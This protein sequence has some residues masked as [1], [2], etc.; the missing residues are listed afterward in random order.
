M[1]LRGGVRL[2]VVGLTLGVALVGH[3]V[4]EECVGRMG[5]SRGSSRG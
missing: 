1:A 3:E 4:Q 5:W 2:A